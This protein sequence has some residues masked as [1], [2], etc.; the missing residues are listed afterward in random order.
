MSK[1]NNI[2]RVPS[3]VELL[4]LLVEIYFTIDG[5][6][7]KVKQKIESIIKQTEPEKLHEEH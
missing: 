3:Y 6:Y 2:K 1:N 4:N 5:Q 7:P